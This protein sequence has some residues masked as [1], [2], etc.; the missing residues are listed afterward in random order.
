MSEARKKT[1]DLIFQLRR[2]IEEKN[3]GGKLEH[4]PS[5]RATGWKALDDATGG[6]LI[7]GALNEVQVDGLAC[8]VLEALLPGLVDQNQTPH[9]PRRFWAWV[10]GQRLPYPPALS[11]LGFDL[12]RWLIVQPKTEQE[13]LW[14]TETILR[15]GLCE[16]LI[17]F[18]NPKS[19]RKNMDPAWRRLQLAARDGNSTALLFGE[20]K[21]SSNTSPAA[22]RLA[23]SPLLG[24]GR[25]RRLQIE[26][27]KCRGRAFADPVLLE[28]SHDA[29]D[30]PAVSRSQSGKLNPSTSRQQNTTLRALRASGA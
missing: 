24:Q 12:D 2:K 29:L 4:R 14:A 20:K 11:Q 15:S 13:Q 17:T 21:W 30:E 22:L 6:G 23:A 10:H 26:I 9:G 5:H 1:S 18:L 27:L 28:W 25:R 8:G 16:G 7:Q 3:G 19:H